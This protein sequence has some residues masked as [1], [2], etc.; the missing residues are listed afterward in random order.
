MLQIFQ[1]DG[2]ADRYGEVE[3]SEAFCTGCAFNDGVVG[4][5]NGEALGADA[6]RTVGSNVG[7]K[8]RL[9]AGRKKR[10]IVLVVV[11]MEIPIL[12]Y[13]HEG[14]VLQGLYTRKTEVWERA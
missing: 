5:Q 4:E 6:V 1:G 8:Q 9:V 3:V 12:S 7:K 13:C 2:T 11:D 14:L 10:K